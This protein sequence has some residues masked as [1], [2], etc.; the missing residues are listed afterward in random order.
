MSK[1]TKWVEGKY[2]RKIYIIE[3]QVFI[4]KEPINNTTWWR[5]MKR[6]WVITNSLCVWDFQLSWADMLS[7]ICPF[8]LNLHFNWFL[9]TCL[10]ETTT[11]SI[12]CQKQGFMCLISSG[13]VCVL[14]VLLSCFVT[15]VLW[16]IQ[17]YYVLKKNYLT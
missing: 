11:L 14:F 16:C 8:S 13:G 3:E 2:R 5:R 9:F 12:F 15:C 10:C 4:L 1:Q 6:L 17:I 7:S